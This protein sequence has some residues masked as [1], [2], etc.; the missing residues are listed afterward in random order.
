MTDADKPGSRTPRARSSGMVLETIKAGTRTIIGS[1]ETSFGLVCFSRRLLDT[2]D[3]DLR[4][5][6]LMHDLPR[7]FHQ[8]TRELQVAALKDPPPYHRPAGTHS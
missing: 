4:Y 8:L 7:R 3:D 1:V 5:K 2:A 6:L